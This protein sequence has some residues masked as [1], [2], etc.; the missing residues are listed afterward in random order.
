M[1]HPIDVAAAPPAVRG[2]SSTTMA[3]RVAADLAPYTYVNLGIGL[4]LKVAAYLDQDSAVLFHS[5]NGLLGLGAQAP[6]DAVD[7]D[8]SDAGKNYATLVE[9]ASAFDSSVSFAIVRGRHLDVAVL[10][11]HQVSRSGDLANWYLPGRTPGVG[12]AMDLALGARQV[13]VMMRLLDRQ[14]ACK[15]VEQCTL[16]LTARGT[17]DRVYSEMGV[18]EIRPGGV[19]VSAVADGFTVADIRRHLDFDVGTPPHAMTVK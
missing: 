6:T 10:G 18:F 14:G 19:T 16:P 8:I 4:P 9:G 5:E 7:L 13:W 2:W 1:E 11:A 15:F 17:V 3:R 12:G